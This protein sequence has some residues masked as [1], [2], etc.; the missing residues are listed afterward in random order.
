MAME[1]PRISGMLQRGGPVMIR[2]VEDAKRVM[3]GPM[4]KQ[5]IAAGSM[6]YTDECDIYGREMA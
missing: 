6:V 1:R 2:M 4:I 3:I 5:T